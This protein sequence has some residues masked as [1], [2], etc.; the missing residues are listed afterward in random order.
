VGVEKFG[1][2]VETQELI[3]GVGWVTWW[4]LQVLY[5]ALSALNV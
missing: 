3:V 4:L 2:L 1:N 5:P